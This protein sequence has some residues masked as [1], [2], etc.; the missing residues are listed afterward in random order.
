MSNGKHGWAILVAT[1]TFPVAAIALVLALRGGG[2]GSRGTPSVGPSP[3]VPPRHQGPPAPPAPPQWAPL[4]PHGPGP[5]PGFG[6]GSGPGPRGAWRHDLGIAIEQ[7]AKVLKLTESQ[8]KAVR[9]QADAANNKLEELSLHIR[10]AEQK[11]R[12]LL[13]EPKTGDKE[14]VAAVDALTKLSGERHKLSILAPWRLRALLTPAQRAQL[15]KLGAPDPRR[16]WGMGPRWHVRPG[17][18]GPWGMGPPP[19]SGGGMARGPRGGPFGMGPPWGGP[20]RP[21]PGAI[22]PPPP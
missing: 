2:P 13:E 20:P 21:G 1:F 15:G 4:A 14:L 3:N 6:P 9:S 11:L 22:A 8:L 7:L 5:G 17:P 19:W 10:R 12:R 16:H 18:G